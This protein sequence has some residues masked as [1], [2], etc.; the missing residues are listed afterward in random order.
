MEIHL[1]GKWISVLHKNYRNV[2]T[3]GKTQRF[4]SYSANINNLAQV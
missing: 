2:K 1:N 4:I 3:L